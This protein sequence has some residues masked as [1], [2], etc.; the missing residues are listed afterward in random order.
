MEYIYGPPVQVS[1]SWLDMLRNPCCLKCQQ[2]TAGDCGGHGSRTLTNSVHWPSTN[3][4][5]DGGGE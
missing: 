1:R 5:R 3:R 4:Q 2:C